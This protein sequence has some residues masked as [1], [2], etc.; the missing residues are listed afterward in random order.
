MI[1]ANQ[2]QQQARTAHSP[3]PDACDA[4]IVGAGASG[5]AAARLLSQAGLAC[6]VLEAR[7]RIGGRIETVVMGDSSIDLGAAW[8]H[9]PTGNPMTSLAHEIGAPTFTTRWMSFAF[10][11]ANGQPIPPDMVRRARRKA[12]RVMEALWHARHNAPIE[13]DVEGGGRFAE[14]VQAEADSPAEARGIVAM[15]GFEIVNE[16]GA[17]L[18]ELSL[19]HFDED[20]VLPGGDYLLPCGYGQLMEA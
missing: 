19:R 10:A 5:L 14:L 20:D 9:G 7:P 6:R 18:H 12:S 3:H 16:H 4:L 11:D 15:L 1:N 13:A 17:S 8:I 2:Q